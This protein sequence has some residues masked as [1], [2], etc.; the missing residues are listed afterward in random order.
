MS[1]ENDE[2][3][4][5]TNLMNDSTPKNKE[6]SNN[7]KFSQN[8]LVKLEKKDNDLYN[9]KSDNNIIE[10]K[11][12]ESV[13]ENMEVPK[14]VMNNNVNILPDGKKAKGMKEESREQEKDKKRRI[15]ELNSKKGQKD[16]KIKIGKLQIRKKSISLL[17]NYIRI[18]MISA[19]TLFTFIK[20][21]KHK[22]KIHLLKGPSFQSSLFSQKSKT[23]KG[24]NLII[25]PLSIFQALSL[26]ANGAKN[27]TLSEMLGL[28]QI[29]TLEELNEINYNIFDQFKD[30][31]TIDIANAVMTK[32]IPLE[33]FRII[34]KKYLAPIEPLVNAD[35]VNKW[36][37]EK[38]HGKI[39]KIIDNIDSK[40]NMLILNAVYFRGKWLSKFESFET[41]KL[42]FYNFG[43]EKIEVNTMTQI[44]HFNFYR[45]KNV[46]AIELKF[47][48]DYMSAI[49]ILPLNAENI[50]VYIDILSLNNDKYYKILD[51]LKM[52]KV[53]LQLPKFE[54]EF[55]ENL[56]Q[57]LINLGMHEA[58]DEFK[59]DFSGLR[60]EGKL[61][62]DKVIHKTYLKVFED[63]CEAA[64][65]TSIYF[66]TLSEPKKEIIY[67]M[68][69]NKPFLFLIKNSKLPKGHDLV[70]MSKIEKLD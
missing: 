16:D 11:L 50:N 41:R 18:V 51:R 8:S 53:N 54:L 21:E 62:I 3:S 6:K 5:G 22:Y 24:N 31:T 35:Q 49:I 44:S 1:F 68:K 60:E 34:S 57:V 28:L 61:Y 59:A 2:R 32:F 19:F 27:K 65:V 48:E 25:S 9:E 46:K 17:F 29:N 43:Y 63:G 13:D 70:F 15:I 4:Q 55:E 47:E 23:T 42:P 10:S 14:K 64:A 20:L 33:E 67:D 26:S 36:C 39:N 38:T 30:F 56:N 12:A 66:D 69:V 37:S 52:A 40:T 45:D 7:S 58:F